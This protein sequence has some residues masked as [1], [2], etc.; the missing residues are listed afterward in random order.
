MTTFG[1][2][3]RWPLS[4][5]QGKQIRDNWPPNT[6]PLNNSFD[7]KSQ[8][9]IKMFQYIP[10]CF[11]VYFFMLEWYALSNIITTDFSPTHV[12]QSRSPT[13]FPAGKETHKPKRSRWGHAC[14]L[15]L[16]IYAKD[17]LDCHSSLHK[18]SCWISRALLWKWLLQF[19]SNC[20]IGELWS[21]RH[22]Q[23]WRTME[24][25]EGQS[26]NTWKR[27]GTLL[28][29]F[30]S[31]RIYLALHKPWEGLVLCVFRERCKHL[32]I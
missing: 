27:K 1:D 5:I 30:I 28:L 6:A 14:R 15:C 25:N 29:L 26:T 23:N 16:L 8:N 9:D 32:S 2:H 19:R 20:R 11:V 7:C 17:V 10:E 12:A 13:L 3:F 18:W 31:C 4:V 21:L 22:E 24:A